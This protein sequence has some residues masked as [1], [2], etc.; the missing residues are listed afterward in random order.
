MTVSARIL[1]PLIKLIL[2]GLCRID[3]SELE[4][5]PRSGPL[6]IVTNHVNFLE[7]PILYTRLFPRDIVGIIKRETWDNPLLG[8]LADSWGALAIDRGASDL[9]AMRSALE[10]L[11]SGKILVL[12]PEGTRSG[13]G[14]L[15]KGHGGVVQIALK[16]GARILPIAHFGGERFWKNLK[17]L[18]RTSFTIRVGQAFTLVPP[19]GDGIP[20]DGAAGLGGAKVPDRRSVPKSVRI[21]MTD[22]VMNRLSLLLPE[23][24]RGAYPEPESASMRYVRLS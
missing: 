21:E 9:A 2:S 12:A 6:I 15:Q 18:R 5:V 13:H 17:S 10:V 24:R 23:D 20:G 4:R 22:A 1:T 8:A 11:D 7:V 3:A 14:R 19:S 16:S